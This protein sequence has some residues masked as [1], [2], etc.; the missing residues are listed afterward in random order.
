MW[1]GS[2]LHLIVGLSLRKTRMMHR[3]AFT[4]LAVALLLVAGIARAQ[5]GSGDPLMGK[6][7]VDIGG[8]RQMNLVC[9]GHGSPAVVFEYGLGGHL[10]NWQKVQ[11]PI[12]ALTTACFYDRAGYGT[13]DPSDRAMTAQNVTDD[14][15]W[16]L[17]K[18]KVAT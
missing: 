12:A 18:A 16:L 11:A 6:H 9:M 3:F 7:L 2:W 14:L 13:S 10:L 5:A 15:Y 17:D 8:R 4:P 1:N